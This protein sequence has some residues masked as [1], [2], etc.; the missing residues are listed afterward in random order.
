V[1]AAAAKFSSK[2]RRWA[3]PSGAGLLNLAQPD[4][5]G[6][7]RARPIWHQPNWRLSNRLAS[8]GFR[9]DGMDGWM[10]FCR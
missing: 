2:A 3:E 8:S 9:A 7:L 10:E 6:P 1:A 5:S 4:A